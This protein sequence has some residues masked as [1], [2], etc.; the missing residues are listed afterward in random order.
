MNQVLEFIGNAVIG[1]AIFG[2]A[3]VGLCCLVLGRRRILVASLLVAWYAVS[4]VLFLAYFAHFG[5]SP[6]P[7]AADWFGWTYL[8][9]GV[10]LCAYF[11]RLLV[12]KRDDS[13]RSR[14]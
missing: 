10:G 4:L 12:N 5:H 13:E 11:L 3:I 14:D 6:A 2:N 9:L 1:I 7:R 8:G